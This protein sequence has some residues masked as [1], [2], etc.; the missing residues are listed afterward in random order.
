M[1]LKHPTCYHQFKCSAGSCPDSCCLGWDVVVDEASRLRF[2]REP[3]A[4]G[5]RLRSA[6][7]V[8]AEG[9]TI[10]QNIDGRCPFLNSNHLCEIYIHLG[11]DALCETCDLYPRYFVDYGSFEESGL[12]F[13][14]PEV[15]AMLLT[16]KNPLTFVSEPLDLDST[17]LNLDLKKS[18]AARDLLMDLFRNRA[19]SIEMR[20]ALALDYTE[21]FLGLF[22]QTE[23][24]AF[25]QL[26][27]DYSDTDF[28]K[29]RLEAL[30]IKT[31][32]TSPQALRTAVFQN[33]MD[34]EHQNS[35]FSEI[36]AQAANHLDEI[37]E[38]LCSAY[39]KSE[40]PNEGFFEALAL[41][42]LHRYFLE[43]AA[44]G[45]ALTS[46]Q[47]LA[48]TCTALSTLLFFRWVPEKKPLDTADYIDVF[49]RY[50]R[51]IEHSLPNMDLLYEALMTE[52]ALNSRAFLGVMLQS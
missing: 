52:T 35:G 24:G 38:T 18:L 25:A 9:D 4:F 26:N 7:T 1:L 31:L 43:D 42:Y 6:M 14:C 29:Q 12:S 19:F 27:A 16:D 22:W 47:L 23:A 20:L 41:Y 34:C 13:S 36:L 46:V 33:L 3:S 32:K 21:A 28:L 11:A 8:D 5:E 40:A 45:E 48:F 50:S 10:F 44:A 17:P 30:K 51:E 39:L 49:Y 37:T 2:N 15:L